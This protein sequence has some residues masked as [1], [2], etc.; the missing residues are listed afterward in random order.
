MFCRHDGKQ[1][2]LYDLRTDPDMQQDLPDGTQ[3]SRGECSKST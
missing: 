2:K 3:E 1:A